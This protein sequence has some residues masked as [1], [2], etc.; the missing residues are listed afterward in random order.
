MPIVYHLNQKNLT[1]YDKL[2]NVLQK[3]TILACR[4]WK[5]CKIIGH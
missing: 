2:T 5:L 4:P 3:Y 1:F